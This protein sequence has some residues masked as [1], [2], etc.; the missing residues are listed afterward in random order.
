MLMIY[1]KK[2][3][4]FLDNTNH[5]YLFLLNKIKKFPLQPGLDRVILILLVQAILIALIMKLTLVMN[6]NINKKKKLKIKLQQQANLKNKMKNLKRRKTRH[7]NLFPKDKRIAMI[8]GS[9]KKY[10]I[11]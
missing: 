9:V 8:N 4:F 3:E 11:M 10:S 2:A 1:L 7:M 5:S 6:K